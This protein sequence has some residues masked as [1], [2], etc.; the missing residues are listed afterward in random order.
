MN[1]ENM[2]VIDKIVHDSIVIE[3]IVNDVFT[4]I[5]K[6]DIIG[7]C[8]EAD[9]LIKTGNLYIYSECE[10]KKRTQYIKNLT[11]SLWD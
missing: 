9:V 6:N 8:K 11:S 10:T 2:Y 5:T 3:N 7:E 1:S 4:I